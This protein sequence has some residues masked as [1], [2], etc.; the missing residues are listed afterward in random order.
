[1]N[2]KITPF[3]GRKPLLYLLMLF[4]LLFAGPTSPAVILAQNPLPPAGPTG[5]QD[6]PL[7]KIESQLLKDFREET[8]LDFFIWMAE[9]ADLS[10]AA[11]LTTKAEK[12]AFV[13][14]ALRETADR[15]Q[16]DVRAILDAEGVSY[17]SFY[18]SNKILVWGGDQG[19]LLSLAARSDVSALAANHTYQLEEPF[20]NPKESGQSLAAVESNISFVNADDVWAMGIDG[21]GT[22]IAGND[23]GLDWD[24]PAL[25]NQYRGWDGAAADHNYNWW[26]ATGTYPTVP[27]DGHGH[28]T[29]TT[30]TMVGDDGGTNQIGMAPGARTIHCKNMDNGGSGEDVTFTTCFQ[31]DL[32]PWDLNGQNPRPDLAPDDINNSW[33]Y[34]GGNI[35]IFMD[36]IA[37]LQ[38]AGILVEVSAGNEGNECQTLGSPSDYGNVLTTGS[39][40]HEGGSLPG[41]LTW[42][43]SRGPSFLTSEYIPDIMAPGENIRSSV[44]G[45][46]YEGGWSGTSMSG[47]HVTGLI[48][49]MWSANPGL[50]GLITETQQ[51]IL[52]TAVPLSGQNGSNCGGDYTTGPN[53]DWGYGTIDALAAVQTA[54]VYGDPGHL[55][56]TVSDAVTTDP[57]PGAEV[58]ARLNPSLK[59]QQA[60]DSQGMYNMFVFSG[61][62]TVTAQ[63]YGYYPETVTGVQVTSFN[64]TTLDL[65]LAPAPSYVVS[66]TITDAATGWP[67]YAGITIDGYPGG[68]VWSD[69][70][71][72]HYSVSLAAG[73]PYV[74]HVTP[75]AGGYVTANRQVG[76]LAAPQSE[77]FGLEVDLLACTAPGYKPQYVYFEDFENDDGGYTI[78]GGFTSWAWGTPTSGPGSAHSGS[79]VWA[80][81]LSGN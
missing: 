58:Q 67:V 66:G 21:S 64:T 24:H 81:N 23:T 73:L 32:A 76:P 59:W 11:K 69:P 50:R 44:P 3:R 25:I 15:T 54:I 60:T 29:H 17:E 42:F 41:T 53:H 65:E 75:F 78:D 20:I 31:W 49:L 18:I 34:F 43:S 30:G 39:V 79:S 71:T 10:P 5:S 57:I 35:P 56:G 62:Y 46:G 38:S 74:F 55:A 40:N 12:G 7:S 70:L 36:E 22:V 33:R 72:G 51:I 61:T 26:D 37:A 47:P 68:T 52:Q 28:G 80:T 13:F 4:C 8:Q 14:N 63:L 2:G 77:D 6:D 45:G 48:G 27:N 19:L 16:R 9:K 1:M